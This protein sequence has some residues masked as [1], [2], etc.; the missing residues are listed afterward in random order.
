MASCVFQRPP[1]PLNVGIP[2]SEGVEGTDH[3]GRRKIPDAADKPAPATAIMLL[4][5]LISSRNCSAS[6]DGIFKRFWV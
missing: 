6:A 3:K 5:F 2:G 1:A 4:H